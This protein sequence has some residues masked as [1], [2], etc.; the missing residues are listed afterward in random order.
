[1]PPSIAEN[2]SIQQAQRAFGTDGG[3]LVCLLFDLGE[4]ARA[5]VK[6]ESTIAYT[7]LGKPADW[8][9]KRF[10]TSPEDRALYAKWA[11]LATSLFAEGKVKV[12][13]VRVVCLD[14]RLNIL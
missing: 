11:K 13:V 7:A 1:M 10:E 5:D 3:H 12:R 2:G 8:S 6:T 4:P 14:R 9:G